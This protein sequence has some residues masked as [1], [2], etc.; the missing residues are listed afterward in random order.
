MENI[1]ANLAAAMAESSPENKL[2]II[3]T[4][5]G[6]QPAG[7]DLKSFD[8]LDGL[9]YGQL[10]HTEIKKLAKQSDVKAV[11]LDMENKIL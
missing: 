11:E 3:V 5:S 10:D 4:T 2:G 6:P 1:A 8:G 9:Y 7:F